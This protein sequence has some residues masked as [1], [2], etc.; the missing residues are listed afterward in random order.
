MA[1]V[2]SYRSLYQHKTFYMLFSNGFFWILKLFF[3]KYFL[4][5]LKIVLWKVRLCMYTF[6]ISSLHLS[7]F[8]LLVE[9]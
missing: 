5:F 4:A 1:R 6:N 9:D 3:G 7:L 8:G 2:K